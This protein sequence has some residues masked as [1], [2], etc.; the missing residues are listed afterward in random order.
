MRQK[1]T[2]EQQKHKSLV[3]ESLVFQNIYDHR[4]LYFTWEAFLSEEF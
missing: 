2:N 1:Q 3:N 4:I